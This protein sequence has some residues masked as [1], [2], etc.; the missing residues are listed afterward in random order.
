MNSG[1]STRI[2]KDVVSDY[3]SREL[4][5]PDYQRE[6]VWSH[7]QARHFLSR[8]MSLG[9]VLGVI[10]TY[11]LSGGNTTF[12]QDGLQRVT[13]LMRAIDK[14]AEYGLA[15]EDVDCLKAAQVSQQS[16]IYLSHDDARTDFQHLNS[17]V[18]LIP[19]EKYRGDLESDSDGRNLYESVRSAVGELSIDLAGVSRA[20][21][22]GR[23]KNGQLHRNALGLFFQHVS[24]HT[25]LVL[26][27]KSERN[28]NEQIERRV[29]RWLDDNQS[30]WRSKF[31]GFVRAIE[32]VNA[33]L[34]D[35]TSSS[36]ARR[37]DMTAVRA[38]YAACAYCRNV[39]CSS[40]VFSALVDWF[41][42]CNGN[43]KT[44]SA[45]FEVNVSGEPVSVRL[46]QVSLRWLERL[47]AVGGPSV[48]CRKREKRIVA[49]A[50]YDE[51]HVIPHA[52]GGTETVVEPATAN[53]AR[54]RAPI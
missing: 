30:D 5:E 54:G 19:Y 35:R 44:W 18:G 46:D 26:Y 24:R 29:R 17:G 4:V 34:R 8:T 20:G 16:M 45:R 15:K 47:E 51:S 23:K 28:L 9:H 33:T 42:S 53:R 41:V 2:V 31:D 25:E 6:Y 32:R 36:D 38:M 37:W 49:R 1:P 14:P 13:T 21:E 52:D 40:D 22:S 12:L 3:R 43:R 7:Q 27:A 39:G 10:T 48:A 50:G 11:R